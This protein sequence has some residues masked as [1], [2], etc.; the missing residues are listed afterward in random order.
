M[1][2]KDAGLYCGPR[3]RKGEVFAYAG[4]PQN[5]K[6]LKRGSSSAVQMA[7]CEWLKGGKDPDRLPDFACP[8]EKHKKV[9]ETAA[10][11]HLAHSAALLELAAAN[12]QGLMSK[13]A[14]KLSPPLMVAGVLCF[15]GS[16]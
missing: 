14:G 13:Q 5:L 9:W 10:H 7:R 6:D 12:K 16:L 1:I 4:L 8:T 15:T 2:R 11:C 3:L